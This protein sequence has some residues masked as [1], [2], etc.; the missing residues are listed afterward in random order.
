MGDAIILIVDDDR[1]IVRLC[2]RLLERAS[3]QVVTALEPYEALKILERQKVNLLLSDLRMPGMDGFDLISQAKKLQPTLP[4]LVMTGFGSVDNALQ[5]LHRGVDGLILKPFEN[6]AD[7]I[8][9]VQ[10]VLEENQQRQDAARLHVLRPLFD[11]TERLLA[12]TSLQPL[13]TLILN[14]MT[15]LFQASN[16]WIYRLDTDGV[17]LELVR[18][19]ETGQSDAVKTAQQQ[20]FQN[21]ISSGSPVVLSASGPGSNEEVQRALQGLGWETLLVAPV[22][23][24]NTQFV[25]CVDR[26]LGS[27]PF[28]EADL[29]LLVVLARQAAVALENARLYSE[30]KDYVHQVEVS[31][32]A[33]VQAEKMAA[34]GQ[35]MA[36][37]AHEINNPLQ[38]VS[39]CLHLA[40]RE[41]ICAED[42][43]TYIDL[44]NSELERLSATVQQMLDFYRP[45][46][47]EKRPTDIHQMMDQV[48]ALLGPQL[49]ERHI[50]IHV[51]YQGLPVLIPVR[52][53]QIKQVIFN[54]I[55]NA[56]DALEDRV[57]KK[58]PDKEIW[59]DIYYESQQIR[60]LI[61]D[62]GPG[63]PVN[64]REH[65]FEPFV[66]TKQQGT[67]LGLAVSYGIIERHQGSLSLVSP[68]YKTGACFEII[69]PSGVE[70][71]NGKNT[72]CR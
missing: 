71:E 36:S 55:L 29:E 32:R 4:V 31:Q 43:L 39:N 66:S 68:H 35:L 60:I 38:A 7:L 37:L 47:G 20:F 25:F 23:R 17:S 67:G 24:D 70:C 51:Q 13:E 69:L 59:I 11:I 5:A 27:I 28:S 56:F 30:L 33:L 48:L 72:D 14:S 64:M 34:M 2:Q 54:L 18:M 62:S 53:D 50:A 16:A 3:Y 21:A 42:R 46:G 26:D 52:P 10:R 45:S 57:K 41:D 63:V 19:T 61:E 58:N 40:S 12:E 8:Q 22:R 65:I 9:T 1:T 6:S 15:G 49:T 44:S